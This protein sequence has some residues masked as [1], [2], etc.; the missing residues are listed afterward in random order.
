LL[1][2]IFNIN[3]RQK[4]TKFFLFFS[5]LFAFQIYSAAASSAAA[6]AAFFE[7]FLTPPPPFF[8]WTA[9]L[10]ASCSPGASSL[11]ARV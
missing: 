10:P 8:S 11:V 7:P 5:R 4:K 9:S 1:Y 3:K 2:F 6:A